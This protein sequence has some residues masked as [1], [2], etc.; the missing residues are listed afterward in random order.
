MRESNSLKSVIP[1]R[2]WCRSLIMRQ[3]RWE[4]YKSK[5]TKATFSFPARVRRRSKYLKAKVLTCRRRFELGLSYPAA[6]R[7][8]VGS[9]GRVGLLVNRE[10]DDQ[11]SSSEATVPHPE[12]TCVLTS[13]GEGGEASCQKRDDAGLVN[14]YG[15]N[16][17]AISQIRSV[18]TLCGFAPK[19]KNLVEKRF[20]GCT[21]KS[22]T[23]RRSPKD[24]E[25]SE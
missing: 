18:L 2:Q 12:F 14:G 24:A 25:E 10:G 7:L 13:R 11:L 21:N 22:N 5:A 15:Q 23:Q 8:S 16:Q 9:D 4:H 1:Y 19:K 17:K 6:T 20:G 3:T